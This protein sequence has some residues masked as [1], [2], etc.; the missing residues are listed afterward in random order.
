MGMAP[1]ALAPRGGV[2]SSRGLAALLYALVLLAQ[3]ARAA[4]VPLLPRI[5]DAHGLSTATTAALIAAPGAATL[6]VALPAGMLADRLGARRVT[7][8]AAALLAAGVLAQAAPALGVLIAGQAAFGIAYGIVWTTAVVWI[9]QSE[10]GGEATARRQAAFVTSA[11][12]GVAAGPA[13]G[14]LVAAR[15]GLGAPFAAVGIAA[16][17]LTLVLATTSAEPRARPD[18]AAASAGTPAAIARAR[19]GIA[20]GAVALALSGATNAVV[21]LLVPLQLHRAGASTGSIGLAFSCAAA[22]YIG[23]SAV[24]V[25]LGRRAVT[26][27]TNA[28]AAVLL[29]LALLPAGSIGTAAAVLATLMLT[30]APRAT[31]STIGYPLA[32]GDAARAGLGHGAAV[33]LLNGAWAAAM[34]VAPLAAG[35]LSGLAGMRATWLATLTAGMLGALWLLARDGGPRSRATAPG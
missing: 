14:A 10:A 15:A 33:G 30:V 22:L 4:L 26:P 17:I 2:R 20:A 18:P 8:A 7:L 35:A 19:G 31:V 27:R 1:H 32:T 6:A 12:V 21:Q 5:A 25:R 34:V 23:A 3:V 11:A 28:L 16:A 9:A 24:V 13:F 29:A